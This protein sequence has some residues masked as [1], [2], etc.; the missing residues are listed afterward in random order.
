LYYSLPIVG[1]GVSL[2]IC[3][4]DVPRFHNSLTGRDEGNEKA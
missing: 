4:R 1:I 2:R 3:A